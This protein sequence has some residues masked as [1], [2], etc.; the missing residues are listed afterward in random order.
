MINPDQ[1][2][3]NTDEPKE[4]NEP[5]ADYKL[6]ISISSLEELEEEMRNYTLLMTSEERL[7]HLHQLRKSTHNLELTE[8]D[9]KTLLNTI[10]INPENEY[11]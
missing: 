4:V 8:E 10:T 1:I 5:V 2:P 7:E 3:E 6:E 11:S 9:K